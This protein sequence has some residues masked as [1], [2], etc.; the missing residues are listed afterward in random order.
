MVD[1]DIVAISPNGIADLATVLQRSINSSSSAIVRLRMAFA[2]AGMSTQ[3]IDAIYRTLGL[4][5]DELPMLRRRHQLALKIDADASDPFAGLKGLRNDMVT[6]GAG[7][8]VYTNDATAWKAGTGDAD[9]IA[10]AFDRS[11]PILP[12][13]AG[14]S[15]I[16][17]HVNENSGDP[18]YADALI[19]RLA[20]QGVAHLAA[21]GM[22]LRR[23][24]DAKGSQLV[25]SSTGSALATSSHHIPDPEVWIGK[26]DA[27]ARSEPPTGLIAPLLKYGKFDSAFL[28]KLGG[29]ELGAAVDFPDSQRSAEIWRALAESP[30]ASA[31]LY[32]DSLPD[33]MGYTN[34]DRPLAP[35]EGK[36]IEAFA[37]V[38]RSA[39]ID[40]RKT[41]PR[42]ADLNFKTIVDYYNQH[43]GY[44]VYDSVR[45]ANADLI[46][47]RWSDLIY[48]IGTPMDLLT[49]S[50]DDPTREGVELPPDAWKAV[51]TDTMRHGSSASKLFSQALSWVEKSQGVI[52]DKRM[53][54]DHS[55]KTADGQKPNFWES[56]NIDRVEA[57][58]NASGADALAQLKKDN[59]DMAKGWIG[60][61]KA[62][63]AEIKKNNVDLLAYEK[64]AGKIWLNA[65]AAHLESYSEQLI[66]KNFGDPDEKAVGDVFANTPFEYR[67]D[68]QRQ[69]IKA[70]AA[71]VDQ[72]YGGLN[73]VNYAG[74]P[75]N[76]DPHLYEKRY[77]TKISYVDEQGRRLLNID[78]IRHDWR[79]LAAYNAWL[80]DPAVANA[81][82]GSGSH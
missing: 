32:G 64:D 77:S 6:A 36:A 29:R 53:P 27:P 51:L 59:T 73:S 40:I 24:G 35:N 12:G 13:L 11:K 23:S 22:D 26:V 5:A 8:T 78:E 20:P 34:E 55:M 52:D 54:K 2:D 76:G 9:A 4:T 39:T 65:Q 18:A 28:A 25:L 57:L 74:R 63:A 75:W 19:N 81:V 44:H 43:P 72:G 16:L 50:G 62:A 70:W 30:N 3:S 47:E 60:V 31:I 14:L 48:S 1:P 33:I 61:V 45:D 46:K 17:R 49:N 67:K 68:W 71:A 38:T 66:R 15:E 10:K 7:P 69:A 21:L 42:L 80:Q 56:Q 37:D 79:K 82:H 41:D 58:I